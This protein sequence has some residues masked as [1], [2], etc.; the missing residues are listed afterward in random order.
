[1]MTQPC[2]SSRHKQLVYFSTT[3]NSL[4]TILGTKTEDNECMTMIGSL[5]NTSYCLIYLVPSISMNPSVL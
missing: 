3:T 4:V 2:D 1:M 5:S